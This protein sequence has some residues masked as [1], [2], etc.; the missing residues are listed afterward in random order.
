MINLFW[1]IKDTTSAASLATVRHVDFPENSMRVRK[2][3]TPLQEGGNN[4]RAGNNDNRQAVTWFKG[5]TPMRHILR[6]WEQSLTHFTFWLFSCFSTKHLIHKYQGL[7]GTFQHI[8]T[9]PSLQDKAILA[10]VG[11]VK[12]HIKNVNIRVCTAYLNSQSV[13]FHCLK[14]ATQSP[15][16]Q[17]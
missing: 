14:H 7:R 17:A 9:D 13:I 11:W 16:L 10:E 8:S 3:R 4:G 12:G 5:T 2:K 15:F 1:V 6:S